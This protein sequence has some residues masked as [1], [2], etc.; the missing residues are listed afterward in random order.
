M[1]FKEWNKRRKERVE[2][3]IKEDKFRKKLFH[4]D[5][6]LIN[7]IL[8]I[9]YKKKIMTHKDLIKGIEESEGKEYVNWLIKRKMLKK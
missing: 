5:L 6:T 3:R 8:E 7:E 1:S 4:L 9:L 2:E